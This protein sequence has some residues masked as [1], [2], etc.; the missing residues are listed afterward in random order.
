MPKQKTKTFQSDAEGPITVDV[1]GHSQIHFVPGETRTIETDD[2][3]VIKALTANP[4]ISEKKG[5]K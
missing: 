3:A 5:K 1:P 4:D 2:P